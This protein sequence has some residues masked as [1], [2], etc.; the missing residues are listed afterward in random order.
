MSR[1]AD[2]VKNVDGRPPP[3]MTGL[4]DG[5]TLE[6]L[7]PARRLGWAN[8][9]SWFLYRYIILISKATGVA[10]TCAWVS[11]LPNNYADDPDSEFGKVEDGF[12]IHQRRRIGA[13]CRRS[14]WFRSPIPTMP[15]A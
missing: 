13:T 14:R 3:T 6:A 10:L 7:I 8:V 9:P 12:V 1:S 2:L 11:H 15:P 4:D 5:A